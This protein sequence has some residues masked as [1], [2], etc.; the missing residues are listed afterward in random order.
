[1]A[2]VDQ[3]G[4]RAVKVKVIHR[5]LGVAGQ[6]SVDGAFRHEV[7]QNRA[8]VYQGPISWGLS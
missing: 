3:T 6:L 5:V 2:V 8:V 4:C 7:P 1:M